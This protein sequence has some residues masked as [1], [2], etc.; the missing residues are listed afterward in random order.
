[1]VKKVSIEKKKTEDMSKWT[2]CDVCHE[3]FE[4]PTLAIQVLDN[5]QLLYQARTQLPGT[6]TGRQAYFWPV[7]PFIVSL[8]YLLHLTNIF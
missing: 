3:M 5:L 1:M 6:V 7:F 2:E 4:T 8:L